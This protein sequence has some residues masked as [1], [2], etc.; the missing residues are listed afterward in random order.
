MKPCLSIVPRKSSIAACCAR[1]VSAASRPACGVRADRS[2]LREI[3]RLLIPAPELE[4]APLKPVMDLRDRI[5]AILRVQQRVGERIRLP[6]SFARFLTPAIGWSEDRARIVGEV[7]QFLSRDANPEQPAVVLHHGRRRRDRKRRTPSH[8]SRRRARTSRSDLNPTSGSARWCSTPCKR[9]DRMCRRAR[10]ALDLKPM[11][12][13]IA[14]A[15]FFLK[16]AGVAQTGFTD[17]DRRHIGVGL[18]ERILGGL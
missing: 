6:K 13:E 7:P 16:T 1:V 5:R 18:G 2:A 14:K 17:V 12:I 15:M 9:S 11:E 3:G 10:H 4:A 8:A